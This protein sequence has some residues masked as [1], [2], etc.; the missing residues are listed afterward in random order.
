MS[1]LGILRRVIES[2]ITRTTPLNHA[3]MLL[4]ADLCTAISDAISSEGVLC[5]FGTDAETRD[6]KQLCVPDRWDV[7]D[8]VR[9]AEVCEHC[10]VYQKA[11]VDMKHRG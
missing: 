5:P 11:Q 4:V 7:A 8:A 9:H 3:D 6:G 1:R 2:V 10:I